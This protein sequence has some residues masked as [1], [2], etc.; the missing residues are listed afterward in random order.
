MKKNF[1]FFFILGI[2]ILS[3]L[4]VYQSAYKKPYCIQIPIAG[5]NNGNIPYIKVDIEG[6]EYFFIIDLGFDCKAS[7]ASEYLSEVKDKVFVKSSTSIGF[8]GN[9][10]SR[11]TYKIPKLKIDKMTFY[12]VLL[13]EESKLFDADSIVVPLKEKR[14]KVTSG[15]V[16]SKLFKGTT[17]CLDLYCSMMALCDSFETF[18]KELQ[19]KTNFSKVPIL[20]EN[21]LIEFEMDTP[22]GTLRCLLDT[23][24]TMNYINMPNPDN[25]PLEEFI[26]N[27][28][29]F[30]NVRIGGKDFGPMTFLPLPLKFPM[31][32]DAIVGLDFLFDHV[33]FID[34]MKHE[35]YFDKATYIVDK[36]GKSM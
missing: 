33:V 1:S 24:S 30:D 20:H 21:N 11:D 19:P 36:D 28:K 5:Y 27:E 7:I 16:G 29:R 25:I 9:K 34:F 2:L 35:I 22:E 18:M 15:A 6:K 23:G 31:H 12:S 32:V 4:W 14:V 3:A 10:Y 17:L 13:E 26:K 8:R